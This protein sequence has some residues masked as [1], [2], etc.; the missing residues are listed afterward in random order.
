MRYL[1]ILPLSMFACSS[2]PNNH[3]GAPDMAMAQQ[4]ALTLIESDYSLT[5]GQEEYLCV[6]KTIATDLYITSITPVNGQA[7]HHEV[8]GIDTSKKAADGVQPCGTNIEFDVISWKLLFASGVNSP[9]LTIPDGAALHIPAG[10]QIVMQMHLLNASKSPVM[11]HASISVLP[12][13]PGGPTPVEA[14]MIL[15][16]PLSDPRVTPAIPVGPNQIVTGSCTLSADTKYFAVFP[17]MH[18]IGTHI[19]VDAVVGGA[20][21]TLWDKDYS[22][23]NQDFGEFT[24]IAMA[25]GDKINVTCTYDNETGMPVKFGQ[26]SLDEMCYAISYVYPP[27]PNSGF[28]DFCRN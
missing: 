17:H 24:P 7:T 6:R 16:G 21:T 28:G 3:P 22:F 23:N 9:T 27:L 4:Q 12:L 14:Q 2:S 1:L 10:S 8:L 13:A 18:Q 20:T 19:K 25:K 5:A 11:S 15:A 26:S